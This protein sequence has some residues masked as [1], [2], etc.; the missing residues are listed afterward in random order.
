ML[1]SDYNWKALGLSNSIN[2]LK[3]FVSGVKFM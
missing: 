2:N 3:V 1:H